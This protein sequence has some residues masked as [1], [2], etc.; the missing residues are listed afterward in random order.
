MSAPRDERVWE[1]GWD[2]HADA[3]LRRLSLL[4]LAQKLD[5]LEEA[6]S[7]VRRLRAQPGVVRE[8][9]TGPK[10]PEVRNDES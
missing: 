3:Q 8:S 10:F 7:R 4:T 6:H 1:Q 9:A 2:G 5:W